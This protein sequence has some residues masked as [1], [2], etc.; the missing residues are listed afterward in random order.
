MVT[1]PVGNPVIELAW[2]VKRSRARAFGMT[3]TIF[4]LMMPQVKK[5]VADPWLCIANDEF[6][7]TTVF[8]NDRSS[9]SI[10]SSLPFPS[11]FRQP[12]DLS[13]TVWF[14]LLGLA[15]S[16]SASSPLKPIYLWTKEN[17]QEKEILS[18]QM[19]V[20]LHDE[21]ALNQKRKAMT[22]KSSHVQNATVKGGIGLKVALSHSSIWSRTLYEGWRCNSSNMSLLSASTMNLAEFYIIN[23]HDR[24][25]FWVCPW[26]W[27][28]H[29]LLKR[30]TLL[31]CPA[32]LHYFDWR[33]GKG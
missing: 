17:T 4:F 26:W 21:S 24:L 16:R 7:L 29:S 28:C 8:R 11:R 1:L 6:L 12:L 9:L 5:T 32:P 15:F 2:T 13:L 14:S 19:F 3:I 22:M 33:G 18:N 20:S 10:R 25:P 31:K 23:E 30:Y 27:G